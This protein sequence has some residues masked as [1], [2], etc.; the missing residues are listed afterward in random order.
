VVLGH[1]AAGTKELKS[2][3]MADRQCATAMYLIDMFALRVGNEKDTDN[4]AETVGCCSLKFE[5][6]TL[7]EPDRVIFD[8]LGK[9][10]IRFDN[11]FPVKR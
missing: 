4:E 2:D 9:D 3:V 7:R 6:I 1:L 8:F 5:H 11:E 10:S